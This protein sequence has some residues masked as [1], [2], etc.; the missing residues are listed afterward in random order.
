VPP[1]TDHPYQP[2]ASPAGTA[3]HLARRHRLDPDGEHAELF[4]QQ[5]TSP[6]QLHSFAHEPTEERAILGLLLDPYLD[7]IL[8]I[9]AQLPRDLH[10]LLLTEV[11]LATRLSG[12][13]TKPAGQGQLAGGEPPAKSGPR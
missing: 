4:A 7:Q 11:A 8:D 5:F 13:P 9:V 1:A 6:D 12:I 3:R 10:P 2:L